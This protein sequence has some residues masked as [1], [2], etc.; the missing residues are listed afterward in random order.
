MSRGWRGS[1]VLF[2]KKK[3]K[4]DY[5]IDWRASPFIPDVESVSVYAEFGSFL[6]TKVMRSDPALFLQLLQVALMCP[7]RRQHLRGGWSQSLLLSLL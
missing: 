7:W 6:L 4:K 5:C 1:N 3:E 2:K